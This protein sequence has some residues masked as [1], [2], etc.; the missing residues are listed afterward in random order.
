MLFKGLTELI[1]YEAM[2]AFLAASGGIA[3]VVVGTTPACQKTTLWGEAARVL[4]IAMPVGIL[5]AMYVSTICNSVPVSYATSFTAG[6]ISLN[7]TRFISSPEGFKALK[8]FIIRLLG[9][10]KR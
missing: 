2:L 1:G 3:R 4:F 8:D 10:G 6:V 7:V 9:G 5:S